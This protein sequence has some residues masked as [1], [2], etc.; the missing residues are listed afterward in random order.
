MPELFMRL[1]CQFAGPMCGTV[2]GH[3][4]VNTVVRRAVRWIFMDF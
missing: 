3:A 2:V 4:T 1:V